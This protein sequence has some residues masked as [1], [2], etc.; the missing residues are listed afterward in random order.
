MKH[1][2]INWFLASPGWSLVMAAMIALAFGEVLFHA[3]S[4]DDV[5]SISIGLTAVLLIG[6]LIR[7]VG[8]GL[9]N[10]VFTKG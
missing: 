4:W 1:R 10:K 8:D 6:F 9:L 5:L 3:Y 2:I 7:F